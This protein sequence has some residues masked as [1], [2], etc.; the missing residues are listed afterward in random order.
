MGMDVN[1][2]WPVDPGM[3]A[4]PWE[5]RRKVT[6][7]FV[8]FLGRYGVKQ[9]DGTR[10]RGAKVFQIPILIRVVGPASETKV[11]GTWRIQEP[12]RRIQEAGK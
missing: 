8:H 12:A 11:W 4:R 1:T 5:D 6:F 7:P 10:P 2:T 9:C 3:G